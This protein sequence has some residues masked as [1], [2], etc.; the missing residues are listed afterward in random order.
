MKQ[1][2]RNTFETNSSST[3]SITMCTA[4]TFNDW[5]EGKCR[6][7]RWAESGK[8]FI[9]EDD[10]LS[11]LEQKY[12]IDRADWEHKRE[13]DPERYDEDLQSWYDMYTYDMW[14][15]ME[16]E[17]YEHNYTTPSGETI[18]AFGHYGYDG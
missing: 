17:T 3:H 5:V 16:Y 18:V 2:R 4:N 9:N 1:I 14:R 13:T 15:S 8:E 7:I 11:Y 12:N 10:I 6:W